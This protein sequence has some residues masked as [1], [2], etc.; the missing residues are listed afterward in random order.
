MTDHHA[1]I[2]TGME[3]NLSVTQ[4]RVYDIITRRFIASFYTDCQVAHTL[5]QG[6][7]GESPELYTVINEETGNGQFQARESNPSPLPWIGHPL[8]FSSNEGK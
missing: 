6:K 2:P 8:F 7:V 3:M 1:I 4:E 5:V